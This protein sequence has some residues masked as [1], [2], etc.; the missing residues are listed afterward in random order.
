MRGGRAGSNNLTAER[1]PGAW[2]VV[3]GGSGPAQQLEVLRHLH[4][5]IHI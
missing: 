1:L 2:L 5:T 4:A 3:T